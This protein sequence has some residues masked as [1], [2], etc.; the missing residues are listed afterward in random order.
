M[1]QWWSTMHKYQLNMCTL[2]FERWKKEEDMRTVYTDAL[3]MVILIILVYSNRN[4]TNEI[5]NTAGILILFRFYIIVYAYTHFV[6]WIF[7]FLRALSIMPA[8]SKILLMMNHCH[9]Q[10]TYI[11]MNA[12]NEMRQNKRVVIFVLYF[13][14]FCLA[15]SYNVFVYLWNLLNFRSSKDWYYNNINIDTEMNDFEKINN[16]KHSFERKTSMDS[17]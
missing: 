7:Q 5:T 4:T 16:M 2:Q 1:N 14:L 13:G 11:L 15:Y 9:I 6:C 8:P 3:L 10:Y 12:I 17:K